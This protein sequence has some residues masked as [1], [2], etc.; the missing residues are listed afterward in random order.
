M[1]VRRIV[2]PAGRRWWR[3]GQGLTDS[4]AVCERSWAPEMVVGFR[5]MDGIDA[6]GGGDSSMGRRSVTLTGYRVAVAI[7]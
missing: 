5:G 1:G 7:G 4:S 2:A 6:G 3:R